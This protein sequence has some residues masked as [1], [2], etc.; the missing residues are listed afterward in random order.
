MTVGLANGDG[1]VHVPLGFP[2][3]PQTAIINMALSGSRTREDDVTPPS[4]PSGRKA[5]QPGG[6]ETNTIGGC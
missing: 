4:M 5:K 3:R 2:C 6:G 1:T